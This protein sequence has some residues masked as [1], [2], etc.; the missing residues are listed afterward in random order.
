M[1]YTIEKT[2]EFNAW[3][4]AMKDRLAKQMV[5]IRIMRA[6][7]GNFGKHKPLRNGVSEMKIDIGKG[8]RVYYTIRQQKIIL[9]LL[10]G[11]KSTQ[12]EDIKK[13][14]KMAER[15]K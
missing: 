6:E 8:Y 12:D 1:Q 11:D 14:I 9:L 7:Q 13:A 4:N 3:Q 10:G 2:D 15:I 5:S